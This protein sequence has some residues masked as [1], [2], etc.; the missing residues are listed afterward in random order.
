MTLV[1]VF[2]A[3]WSGNDMQDDAPFTGEV[4]PRRFELA[5]AVS[6]L[7]RYERPVMRGV[8][9]PLP[10]GSA[11]EAEIDSGYGPAVSVAIGIAAAAGVVIALREWYAYAIAVAVLAWSIALPRGE[12]AELERELRRILTAS[13]S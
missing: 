1:R 10:A 6:L 11:I 7:K 8:I 3:S 13:Q 12:V 9:R 5:L 4:L 2:D